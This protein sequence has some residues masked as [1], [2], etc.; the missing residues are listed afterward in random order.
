MLPFS[1]CCFLILTMWYHLILLHGGKWA[2]KPLSHPDVQTLLSDWASSPS[3]GEERK[4]E[5]KKSM[6]YLCASDHGCERLEIKEE[7]GSFYDWVSSPSDG[8]GGEHVVPLCIWPW[9][10]KI[11]NQRREGKFPWLSC[12]ASETSG[13]STARLRHRS[14]CTNYF[15]CQWPAPS[16]ISFNGEFPPRRSY[17]LASR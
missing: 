2:K 8:G 14:L 5:E 9:V 4:R 12:T 16:Q 17:A 11:G 7:K 6:L 13:R 15:T 10:S 3:N 1:F